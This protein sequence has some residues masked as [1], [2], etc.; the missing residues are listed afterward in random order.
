MPPFPS[1]TMPQGTCYSNATQS[2]YTQL[3]LKI[4]CYVAWCESNA[5][6]KK[7]L[8]IRPLVK[9]WTSDHLRIP[10]YKTNQLQRSIKFVGPKI[11]NS[12]PLKV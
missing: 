8:D 6:Q 9:N 11:W 3:N 7:K 2:S 5:T 12:I 4:E 1:P 10:L